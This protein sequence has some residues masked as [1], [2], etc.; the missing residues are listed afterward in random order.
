MGVSQ[1]SSLPA[2]V[3]D[4]CGTD[5]SSWCQEEEDERPTSPSP[6]TAHTSK[7]DSWGH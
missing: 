3:A 1:L 4:S 2:E 6:P 7:P 5:N